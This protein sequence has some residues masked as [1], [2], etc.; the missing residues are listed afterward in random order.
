M[1]C[2]L[3][4]GIELYRVQENNLVLQL[5]RT[6]ARRRHLEESLAFLAE[7]PDACLLDM[8]DIE[9]RASVD[10]DAW[11]E[12]DIQAATPRPWRGQERTY[13]AVA[14]SLARRQDWRVRVADVARA[15]KKRGLSDAKHASLYVTVHKILS[16]RAGWVRTGPGEFEY[17]A[18]LSPPTEA[19]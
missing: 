9:P 15:I 16:K 18:G 14:V 13:S 8:S 1:S 12:P 5:Q 4:Q 17:I 6:R 3:H 2:Q 19:T 11:A 10:E 7:P